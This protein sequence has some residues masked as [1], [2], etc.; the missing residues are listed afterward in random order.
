MAAYRVVGLAA[1]FA[2]PSRNAATPI[3]HFPGPTIQIIIPAKDGSNLTNLDQILIFLSML[4]LYPGTHRI[5][6]RISLVSPS[7]I[8]KNKE[9]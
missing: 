8:N 6:I 3:H 9:M 5:R 2:G 7:R 4:L 1:I